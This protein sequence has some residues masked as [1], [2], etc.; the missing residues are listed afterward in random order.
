MPAA[1]ST[2]R[3]R[4][5]PIV[6]ED[7]EDVATVVRVARKARG[8]IVEFDWVFTRDD[9]EGLRRAVYEWGSPV[10]GRYK[11][12]AARVLA[13]IND[14][15]GDTNSIFILNEPKNSALTDCKASCVGDGDF[16]R[17]HGHAPFDIVFGYGSAGVDQS[18]TGSVHL[19]PTARE[20]LAAAVGMLGWD[21]R[22][23]QES[24][25]EPVKNVLY[26]LRMDYGI[27]E[28]E[29]AAGPA[30][31]VHVHFHG[32]FSAVEESGNR[33]LFA[34]AIAARTGVYLWTVNVEGKDRP[35]YVG[36]TR[37][38]FGQRMGEHLAGFLSGQYTVFDAA[39]L[40]RGE[41]RRAVGTVNGMWP[42]TLPSFLRN[43]ERLTPN[44]IGLIRLIQFHVAP[45][46]GDGHLHDR[47]EG[48][49]GHHYKTHP[50]IELRDFFSPGLRVPA[51]VPYDTPIRLVLSSEAPI[52]GLPTHLN[53]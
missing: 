19:G 42:Q 9:L 3:W 10:V 20:T 27:Q 1:T 14:A 39:A 24:R 29:P 26:G 46:A 11:C 37:R 31:D 22:R 40:S 34:D 18:A 6:P 8:R 12:F 50:D 4:D 49:I 51:A 30:I 7:Y 32:P 13:A 17:L 5:K 35:W 38:G 33:C 48:A 21:L 43:Y 41:N 45:L 23:L 53:A 28:I 36:Q 52:A 2:T 15:I 25:L 16:Y 47:V 44:I